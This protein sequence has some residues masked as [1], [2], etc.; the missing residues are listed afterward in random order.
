MKMFSLVILESR[1][2]TKRKLW[3]LGNFFSILFHP[4]NFVIVFKRTVGRG[5]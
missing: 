3:P 4:I 1:L 2:Q 5:C